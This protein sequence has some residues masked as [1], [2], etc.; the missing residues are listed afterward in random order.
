[1]HAELVSIPTMQEAWQG[2][3]HVL[4]TP[5]LKPLS[6]CSVLCCAVLPI[7]QAQH[8]D[9]LEQVQQLEVLRKENGAMAALVAQLQVLKNDQQHMQELCDQVDRLR[10]DNASLQ[11]R[12]QTLPSLQAENERLTVSGV[13][14]CWK[15]C[16]CDKHAWMAHTHTCAGRCCLAAQQAASFLSPPPPAVLVCQPTCTLDPFAAC[17]A[18][19]GVPVWC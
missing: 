1:M 19:T 13:C 6:A 18:R 5:C 8:S 4:C 7:P 15:L 9:L 11:R 17:C 12:S 10:A 2:L 14:S 16:L 3:R